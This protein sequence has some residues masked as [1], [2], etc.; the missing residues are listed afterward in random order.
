MHDIGLIYHCDN[1]WE[2]FA[3]HVVTIVEDP[4]TMIVSDLETCALAN[5]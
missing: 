3:K 2:L 4:N 5:G 1:T